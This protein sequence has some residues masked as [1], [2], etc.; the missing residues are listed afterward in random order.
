[1]KYDLDRAKWDSSNCKCLMVI[2]ASIEDPIRGSI[3]E[4]TTTTEYIKK[5]ESQFTGSSKAY[6]STLIKKLV[7]E[8]YTGGGISEHILK[9]SNTTSKFKPMDMGLK[10]EFLVHLIFASLPKEYETF[11][12]NYNLQPDKWDIEKLI[13]MCVPEEK[14]LK[15]SHGDSVNH[16]KENK[17]K[18]F[19]NKNA[20]PQG[21]PQWDNSSSSK[22]QGKAP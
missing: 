10:D 18:N 2:K 15:S 21:K 6:A 22:S 5:V 3:P 19:N 16:V 12:V 11:V 14:R 7:N 4:C 9:M 20:K 17:K 8:K 1:M 13:A